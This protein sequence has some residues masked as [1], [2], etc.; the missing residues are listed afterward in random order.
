MS[1]TLAEPSAPSHERQ[2]DA[3]M[4]RRNFLEEAAAATSAA[5]VLVTPSCRRHPEPGEQLPHD[6]EHGKDGRMDHHHGHPD[7]RELLE[8]EERHPF[9]RNPER[10]LDENE[11]RIEE[12]C[13]AATGELVERVPGSGVLENTDAWVARL[14]EKARELSKKSGKPVK[15]ILESHESCGAAELAFK[16]DADPDQRAREA[17]EKMVEK[18]RA[19]GVDAEHGGDSSFNHLPVHNALGAT[20]DFTEGRMVKAPLNTFVISSPLSRRIPADTLLAAAISS[21]DHSYGALLKQYTI[22]AFVD[23]D[24]R[25][26]CEQ[27]LREIDT[28]AAEFRN[29][30]ID[31]RIIARDAP[32]PPVGYAPRTIRVK[33]I[34]ERVQ[35]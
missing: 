16:G 11:K 23:R 17:Q 28:K 33:C 31:V 30:G 19:Q 25:A 34:D 1:E 22:V 29:K 10:W 13:F 15:V 20:I 35:G 2:E 6:A 7:M 18:L 26:D 14:A 12:E 4:N 3:A 32:P 5:I 8:K 27:I 9:Y 24:R 21:G